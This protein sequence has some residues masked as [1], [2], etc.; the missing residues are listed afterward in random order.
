MV[1]GRIDTFEVLRLH[2]AGRRSYI[3]LLEKAVPMKG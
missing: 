1:T 2:V 3:P